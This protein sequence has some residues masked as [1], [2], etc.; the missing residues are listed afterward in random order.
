MFPSSSLRI[1]VQLSNLPR[2][3]RMPLGI[4]GS[5]IALGMPYLPRN[6]QKLRRSTFPRNRSINLP[7]IIQ[8]PLQHLGIPAAVSLISPSHQQR[9]VPLL[10]LI[11]RKVRM[12]ALGDIAKERLETRRRVKLL[13]L[14]SLP[15]RCIMGLLSLPTSL[16]GPPTRRVGIVQINL[17]LRYPRLQVIQLGIKHPNLPKIT[18]LKSLKLRPNL[19][20][21]RL[22]LRKR[23]TNRS[24]LLPLIKQCSV[25]RTLL[26]DDLG[27]HCDFPRGGSS[28]LAERGSAF[29]RWF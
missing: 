1:A 23:R 20:K 4:K 15:K 3:Q 8:Q 17:P 28:S 16:L 21:L 18:P 12:Y 24:K 14:P 19:R 11:P 13:S 22:P 27:W 25:V 9:K 10:I 26:K 6:P 2:H 29:R 5:D 7:M